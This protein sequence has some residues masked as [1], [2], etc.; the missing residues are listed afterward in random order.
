MSSTG[1]EDEHEGGEGQGPLLQGNQVNQGGGIQPGGDLL[2]KV[3]QETTPGQGDDKKEAVS[4][5]ESEKGRVGI[6]PVLN[7]RIQ[8]GVFKN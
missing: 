1:E 3:R 6:S 8:S 2:G 5:G 7:I 4:G